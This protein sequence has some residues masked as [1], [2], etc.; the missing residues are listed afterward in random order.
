MRGGRGAGGPPRG[1]AG[2]RGGRGAPYTRGS[3]G[4]RGGRG[5]GPGNDRGGYQGGNNRN[6][7]ERGDSRGPGGPGNQS[8]EGGRGG[9][10]GPRGN[11]DG[12]RGGG[13]RGNRSFEGGRGNFDRVLDK[14]RNIEGPQ[15]DLPALDMSERKFSGRARIYIGNFTTEMTEETL[16]NLVSAEGEVGEMFF[17]RE[18]NFAFVRMSTRSEAE[19]VKQK[20]DG[21][22]KNGRGLKVRFSPHQGAVKVSNLGDMVSNELLHKAFSIFGEIERCVVGIDARGRS[23]NEAIVEFEKKPCAL[24]CVKR[25]TEGCFFL[26]TSLR[27]VIAEIQE[28]AEDD[29]GL[30]EAMLPKRNQEYH[31]ERETGPRFANGGSFE[32]EYGSKWK[33]LYDM[34]KQKLESLERE[35]KL[36]EEKLIAQMEFARYEHETDLLKNQLR[37][38]EQQRDQQKQQWESKELQMQEQ[39]KQEQE[40]RSREEESMM[41]RM[42]EQEAGMRRRTE[43]NNL[44]MQ[45]QELNSMLDQQEANMNNRGPGGPMDGPGGPGGPFGGPGGPGGPG[46]DNSPWGSGGW[47]NNMGPGGPG[48]MDNGGPFGGPGGNFNRGGP[49]GPGGPGGRG[50]GGPGGPG[51]WGGDRGGHQNKRRRF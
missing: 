35:M 32:F 13:G 19:K 44:F 27:P 8:F 51:P 40:R 20:L 7:M 3:P 14:L 10:G 6:S 21:Q 26:T 2:D 48:P 16:K 45:A 18:K 29:G 15:V 9:S 36:E 50:P 42:Q 46:P 1:G 25:C 28:E 41:Q 33:A 4:G 49:G 12:G 22:M 11:F 17:N 47:D 5:G 31:G 43:E 38:R 34:K 39:M 23:T 30:Q 37:Q 24:E